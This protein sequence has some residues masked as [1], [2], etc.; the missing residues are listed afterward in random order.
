MRQIVKRVK[1]GQE[2]KFICS[3]CGAVIYSLFML[4][5]DSCEIDWDKLPEKCS[6]G[7]R[8]TNRQP[9]I[10]VNNPDVNNTSGG[11]CENIRVDVCDNVYMCKQRAVHRDISGNPDVYRRYIVDLESAVSIEYFDMR[12][13]GLRRGNYKVPDNI[14]HLMVECIKRNISHI[15]SCME[16]S[17]Y[18]DEYDKDE[19]KERL[20]ILRQRYS[21]MTKKS[22]DKKD[23]DFDKKRHL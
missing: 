11:T 20:D 10:D 19:L 7:T 3:V 15:W 21:D 12:L 23:F 9:I 2:V 16:R 8:L 1:N 4:A 14:D 13:E 6:C 17:S 18:D 22:G 5:G